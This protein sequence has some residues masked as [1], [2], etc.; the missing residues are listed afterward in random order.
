MYVKCACIITS[1]LL[2]AGLLRGDNCFFFFF[3]FFYPTP[4]VIHMYNSN[5]HP[6]PHLIVYVSGHN[7]KK[8]KKKI[9][10]PTL[11]F[12]ILQS[13]LYNGPSA[14]LKIL[15]EKSKYSCF[16]LRHWFFHSYL[17]LIDSKN[18]FLIRGYLPWTGNWQE[19]K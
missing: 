18:Y 10:F 5:P 17:I 3:K 15:T 2:G 14:S 19:K 7:L 4:F 8:K 13:R 11:R 9:L 6:V 12:I 1:K 16:M